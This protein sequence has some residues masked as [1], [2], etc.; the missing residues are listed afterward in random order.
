MEVPR[1]VVEV[2]VQLPAFTTA[3]ATPDLSHIWTYDVA[4]GDP[5]SLTH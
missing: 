5:G 2:E 1:I 4:Q 3:T